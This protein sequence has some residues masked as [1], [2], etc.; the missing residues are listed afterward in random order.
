MVTTPQGTDF[1][2][3]P[4]VL[5]RYGITRRTLTRWMSETSTNEF[6]QPLVINGRYLWRITDIEA[7]ERAAA[8]WT[9]Q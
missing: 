3:V 7:W 2:K 1:L 8:V 4:A 9:A 5:A 6:P